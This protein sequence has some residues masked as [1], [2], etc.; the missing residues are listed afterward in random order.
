MFAVA[1]QNAR[2]KPA[3]SRY[4][5][6]HLGNLQDYDLENG[7]ASSIIVAAAAGDDNEGS[8]QFVLWDLFDS[9]ADSLPVAGGI[10]TVGLGLKTIFDT[11]RGGV[12]LLA[13]DSTFASYNIDHL[14]EFYDALLQ[15]ASLQSQASAIRAVVS[16]QRIQWAVPPSIPTNLRFVADGSGVRLEWQQPG[17]AALAYSIER[18][19]PGQ[20]NFST[21]TSTTEP[22]LRLVS[23]TNGTTYRVYAANVNTARFTAP[24]VSSPSAEISLNLN[25]GA[26]DP[27]SSPNPADA[28]TGLSRNVTLSWT[29]NQVVDS[30]DVYFGTSTSPPM[31]ANTTARSHTPSGLVASTT[32]YWRV[33]AKLGAQATSSP[34]WSFTT[35]AD[36]AT[37][38]LR[39][40][41]VTPCRLVDTREDNVGAAFGQPALGGNS[42]RSFPIPQQT[43]C[44]IPANAAAYSLNVTVVPQGPLGYLTIWPTGTAQ[45]L[46]STL[47]SVDGRVKANAA[48]VPAG[49]SGAI[50]IF[51]TN[52][53]QLV[54]DING[55]FIDPA[56]NA[57]ALSFYPLSPCRIIDTRNPDGQLG[58]PV[59]GAGGNKTIPI[60]L[61]NCGVP[62][63]AQAYSINATVVPTGPLGYLTLWPTGQSQPLVSTLNAPTGN[64][65]ANAAIVPAGTNGS[66]SAFMSNQSH[67]VVDINGYFAPPGS[68][69]AQRFFAVTPCRLLDTRE[70][71][72]EL[73]GPVL[74]GNTARSYRLQF[75]SCGLPGS[76]AAYSLN[77]TVVPTAT[78][79]YL[80]LWPSGSAQP[81]V[82]TLNAV[83]DSVVANAAIVPAGAAG[84]VASFVTNPTHLILDTNGY[85]SQ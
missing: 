61:S 77:A 64:V 31:V 70:A 37:T 30:M 43:R 74:D 4:L 5:S 72:G 25:L 66:I 58:G 23:P 80:T 18:R 59:I 15:N 20:V 44:G 60:R 75:A 13:P 32:Y 10:D 48:I 76:A 79:G 81:L 27:P 50:S 52:S 53:T 26:P 68:A 71:V 54:L 36:P 69:N 28:A 49:V 57:Q 51:V 62:A 22:F 21:L 45:P 55:Y 3:K 16:D 6:F 19:L 41:P 9:L 14:E 1:G 83:G 78:L 12:V 7:H 42:V 82:S 34:V 39:F 40:V 11:A 35:V 24:F 67:L 33:V 56:S 29:L 65:V 73:G 17:A 8:V 38:G 85:F 63:N 47:N 46:V 2:G 84:A